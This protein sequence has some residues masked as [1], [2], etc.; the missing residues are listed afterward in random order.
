MAS[1]KI[2]K[3]NFTTPVHFGNARSDYGVSLTTIQSD[4]MYAAIISCIAKLGYPIPENGDIG[5]VISSLFPFYQKTEGQDGTYFFPKPLKA[6]T[7]GKES[8]ESAKRIKRVSWLDKD[9]FDKAING[10]PLFH[11][12]EALSDIKSG[13]YLTSK[14]IMETKDDSISTSSESPRVKIH[15]DPRKDSEPF[16]M[17]RV[18]FNDC[19]GLFFLADGDT[20]LLDKGMELLQHE[21]LGTDRNVGNGFFEYSKAEIC[22]ETPDDCQYAMSL[23][24]FIPE[25]EDQI[26]QLLSGE[27]AAYEL[28]RRGGWIT[29][30][31]YNRLRKNSIYA[32]SA[33]SIFF[34]DDAPCHKGCI[35]DLSP[36]NVSHPV[37]RNGKAIFIPIKI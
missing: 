2:Y 36:E 12:D 27:H 30:F 28:L 23:S 17:E 9:Y 20:T 22:L 11:S 8:V 34:M 6:E 18:Y 7:L 33:G 1:F 13:K 26:K 5:C 24:T 10:K 31:P 15:K 16:F 25:S 29:S 32:F 4:T 19:S 21:G 14:K 37:W 35:I 3:L